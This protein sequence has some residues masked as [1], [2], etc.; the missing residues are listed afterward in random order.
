MNGSGR[1][2]L[3]VDVT[4]KLGAL[5]ASE[6]ELLRRRRPRELAALQPEKD[7]LSKIYDNE[8]RLLRQNP[9][10]AAAAPPADK[11]QL[12]SVI[13]WFGKILEDHHRA[14]MVAKTVT[15]RLVKAVSEEVSSRTGVVA[16]YSKYATAT[17]PAPGARRA[18][19]VSLAVNQVI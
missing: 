18:R 16:G 5:I 12:R 3:L 13:G 17:T 7:R 14:L 10:V 19:P 2:A 1:I 11:E 9:A 8:M 4:R 15:E 6:T